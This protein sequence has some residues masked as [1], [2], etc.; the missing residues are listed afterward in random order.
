M[1]TLI[2]IYVVDA[3]TSFAPWDAIELVLSTKDGI[4]AAAAAEGADLRFDV[5]V[6]VRPDKSG[7]LQGW[8]PAVNRQPDGRRFIYLAWLGTTGGERTM[9]RRLKVFL[10]TVSLFPGHETVYVIHV[11]GKDPRGGPACA[12]A[13]VVPRGEV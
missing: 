2:Q 8:G 3:P 7:T 13:T 12:S 10:D 4:F 1:M 9:F 6:E 5:S 11:K